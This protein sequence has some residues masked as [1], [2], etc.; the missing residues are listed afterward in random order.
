MTA[1]ELSLPRDGSISKERSLKVWNLYRSLTAPCSRQPNQ[2]SC[3][4]T[5]WH[6][7]FKDTCYYMTGKP[8]QKV[9][10]IHRSLFFDE[11]RW[12]RYCRWF[13]YCRWLLQLEQIFALLEQMFALICS[14]PI[15]GASAS[16][17]ILSSAERKICSNATIGQ[18]WESYIAGILKWRIGQCIQKNSGRKKN[19]QK[20]IGS[21]LCKSTK[22][23]QPWEGGQTGGLTLPSA[24]SPCFAKLCGR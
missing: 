16:E 6:W 19:Y 22:Q 9:I 17:Q 1:F 21:D 13:P 5:F 18:P 4:F 12:F 20:F 2:Q 3:T 10:H 11:F 24:L 8:H 15:F 7:P 23:Y 14:K